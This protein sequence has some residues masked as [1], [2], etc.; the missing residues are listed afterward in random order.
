MHSA[1]TPPSP[2]ASPSGIHCYLNQHR[3]E[4]KAQCDIK[5]SSPEIQ[6]TAPRGTNDTLA[7]V[8]LTV[9]NR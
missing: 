7:S 1:I 3:S 9:T 5:N 6:Q 2:P 4:V 8:D